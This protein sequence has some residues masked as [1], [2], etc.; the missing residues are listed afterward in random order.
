VGLGAVVWF[1][2][3]DLPNALSGAWNHVNGFFS[4]IGAFFSGIGAWFRGIFSSIA[5]GI[6]SFAAKI[7]GFFDGIRQGVKRAL[8]GVVELAMGLLRKIP[9]LLLP[10]SLVRLK[11]QSPSLAATSATPKQAAA[12]EAGR[13]SLPSAMPAVSEGRRRSEELSG[14]ADS[15]ASLATARA[16]REGDHQMTFRLEVDGETIAQA[17]H[18]ASRDAANRAFSP[19]P[20]Y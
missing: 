15:I 3:E 11:H 4:R 14:L 18:N 13:L 12:P 17:S 8:A 16:K 20:V 6:G 1:L 5:D 19:I 2:T 7:N 9:D 10:E